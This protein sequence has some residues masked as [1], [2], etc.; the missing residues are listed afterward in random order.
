MLQLL[1]PSVPFCYL[2]MSF[3]EKILK[4]DYAQY[5]RV[6]QSMNFYI[7]P[8]ILCG[9]QGRDLRHLCEIHVFMFLGTNANAN[10]LIPFSNCLLP[11]HKN[12][13][14]FSTLTLSPATLI[15]L[16]ISSSNI[17]LEFSGIF[18]K[19]VLGK[20]RFTIFV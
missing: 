7:S 3:K 16:L 14:D 20:S 9:F 4:L 1:S 8:A 19:I 18:Y 10:D 6:F 12:T 13:I 5:L 2:N 17:L 15:N 11:V